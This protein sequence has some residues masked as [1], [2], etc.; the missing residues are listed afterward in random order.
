M[1]LCLY[2]CIQASG[3]QQDKMINR[4]TELEAQVSGLER[5]LD[6]AGAEGAASLAEQTEQFV[7]QRQELELRIAQQTN[8]IDN[9]SAQ[10]QVSGSVF[11]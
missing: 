6:I 1:Y 7:L 2:C 8:D 5:H 10:L 3:E 11:S 9:L 4:I